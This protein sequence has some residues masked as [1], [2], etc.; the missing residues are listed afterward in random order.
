MHHRPSAHRVFQPAFRWIAQNRARP[1]SPDRLPDLLNATQLGSLEVK[2]GVVR[3]LSS[4]TTAEVSGD[5]LACFS[6]YLWMS[7]SPGKSTSVLFQS[8]TIWRCSWAANS[9]KS[10]IFWS[11]SQPCP[12]AIFAVSRHT[13]YRGSIQAGRFCNWKR[14]STSSLRSSSSRDRSYFEAP[15][16]TSICVKRQAGSI[17][18][19][20]GSSEN[21]AWKNGFRPRSRC[22]RSSRTK[23]SKGTLS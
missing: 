7:C 13:N 3:D 20:G 11:G 18:G 8:I 5:F 21:N 22:G 14:A 2:F 4:N 19:K 1:Q 6:K 16:F 10:E 15:V 12:R 17:S 9:G 23:C